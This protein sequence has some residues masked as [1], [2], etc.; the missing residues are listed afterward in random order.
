MYF[1]TSESPMDM[2]VVEEEKPPCVSEV[3]EYAAEIHAHLR[4]MEVSILF[5]LGISDETLVI[6]WS[7]NFHLYGRYFCAC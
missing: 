6:A 1:L 3:T 4:E 2:S 5:S 7:Q